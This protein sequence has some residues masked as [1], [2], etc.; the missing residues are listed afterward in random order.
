[1]F[2]AKVLVSSYVK[3]DPKKLSNRAG[4]LYYHVVDVP[5][6]T[7]FIVYD[8]DQLYPEYVIQY[9]TEWLR[10]R[11]FNS[12]RA[13]TSN[14]KPCSST[15]Q[16]VMGSI[17]F[18]ETTLD[19]KNIDPKSHVQSFIFSRIVHETLC[20]HQFCSIRKAWMAPLIFDEQLVVVRNMYP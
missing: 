17:H 18:A 1:M 7:M 19:C 20:L 4:T 8:I 9:Q 2:V 15:T 14:P 5:K 12:Q 3:G 6:P 11:R 13:I 16:C 10:L